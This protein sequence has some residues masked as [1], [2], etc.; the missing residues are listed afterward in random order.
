MNP[1]QPSL[2]DDAWIVI[3]AYNEAERIGVVL[4]ELTARGARNIAVVDDGSQDQ[5][6]QIASQSDVWVL[7]HI[8]NR[9]QGAALQT[10]I[11]FAIGQGA[12]IIV[13]FDADGQHRASDLPA[14]VQPIADG[15]VDV[16]L[17]SRFLGRAPGIPRARRLLL[18]VGVWGTRLTTGMHVTDA[19]NGLR[20]MSAK[21]TRQ[22]AL[23]EDGMAHASELLNK[24]AAAR[25]RWREVPVT[26]HYTEHS[27]SKG[28]RNRAAFHIAFR[29]LITR[30]VR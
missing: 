27:L 10:G 1:A 24:I 2:P 6:S 12:K 5:T 9:G 16:V 30:V 20:A 13:T 28:Q 21:A 25:L 14:L 29:M 22:L 26:I 4:R 8:V 17:G 23:S 15:Q 7:R 19:H 11:E 18:K 3:P